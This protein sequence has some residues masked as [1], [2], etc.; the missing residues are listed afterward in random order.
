M[1]FL[2]WNKAINKSLKKIKIDHE[3]KILKLLQCYQI[4]PKRQNVRLL[5]KIYFYKN[6]YLEIES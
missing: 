4:L 2:Y 3:T 6:L 1:Q 5:K